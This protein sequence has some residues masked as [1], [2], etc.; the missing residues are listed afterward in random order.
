MS[1][2]NSNTLSARGRTPEEEINNFILG[3]EEF[4]IDRLLQ[5][6]EQAMASPKETNGGDLQTSIDAA[7][8]DLDDDL[9]FEGI[10]FDPQYEEYIGL[11]S[12]TQGYANGMMMPT[13]G[14]DYGNLQHTSQHGAFSYPPSFY[15]TYNTALNIGSHTGLHNPGMSQMFPA[16]RFS[17]PDLEFIPNFGASM[18]A[19]HGMHGMH[20]GMLPSDLGGDGGS[21]NR[22]PF[23]KRRVD[24]EALE[25]STYGPIKA[26]ILDMSE[27][28]VAAREAR[29]IRRSKRAKSHV[30]QVLKASV[31]EIEAAAVLDADYNDPYDFS[32]TQDEQCEELLSEYMD[33]FDAKMF[34]EGVWEEIYSA[35]STGK[36]PEKE[37]EVVETTTAAVHDVKPTNSSTNDSVA[38]NLIQLMKRKPGFS[39]AVEAPDDISDFISEPSSTT[40]ELHNFNANASC[41]P[42]TPKSQGNIFRP[43]HIVTPT[44]SDI[45]QTKKRRLDGSNIS[46]PPMHLPFV[47]NILSIKTSSSPTTVPKISCTTE[48][49]QK[50]ELY[51]DLPN[52]DDPES[53]RLRRLMRNRLSAQKSRDKRKSDIEAYT[54]IK[55][56]KDEEI[57]SMKK[58]LADE[59][60]G[61]KK[62]EDM[63]NYAKSFLGAA[64]FA[65]VV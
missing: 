59:M 7:L 18:H 6:S 51:A 49:K 27:A 61:L 57:D 42:D 50:G 13:H 38:A 29:K 16:P 21:S 25:P 1:I 58:T 14:F 19:M 17:Y 24:K 54:K 36:K 33:N 60:E 63:V 44:G 28:A 39:V 48:T 8:E 62:L 35:L 56:Q 11:D 4:D 10:N 53:R 15:N 37:L 9:N 40:L 3:D 47:N 20:G 45:T 55:A 65:T 32:Q 26:A 2:N 34:V 31:S 46:H 43:N 64:K 23:K 12:L 52:G 22:R 5:L 30:L 41:Q